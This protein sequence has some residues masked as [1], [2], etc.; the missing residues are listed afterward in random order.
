MIQPAFHRKA[1]GALTEIIRRSN[2]AQLKRWEQA[3]RKE[4]SINVTRDISGLILEVTLTA[5]F[6]SDYEQAAPHFNILSEESARTFAFAQAFRSLGKIVLQ[7]L[8]Q[9]R[10]EKIHLQT[11][12]VC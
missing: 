11:F 4:V 1:I 5:I 2:L 10:K 3:A 12:L 8:A 7:L 9:R 6:G